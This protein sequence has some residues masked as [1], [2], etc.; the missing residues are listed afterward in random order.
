MAERVLGVDPGTQAMGFGVVEAG[1]PPTPLAWGVLVP[2]RR[3]P[4]ERRLAWLLERLE[5]V[6]ERWGPSALA[7]EEPFTPRGGRGSVRSA[8]AVGQAQAVAL[9]VAGRRGLPVYRYTAPQVKRAVAHYGRGTKE[10]VA[11]MVRLILGLPGEPLPAD[12]GDAL[13]LALC[14]LQEVAWSRRLEGAG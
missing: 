4:L 10:Q 9:L 7:V 11:E 6:A 3:L 8:L 13:A 1:E 5:A 2:P 12:A 14:H